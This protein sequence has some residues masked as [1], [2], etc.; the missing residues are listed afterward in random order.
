V[1]LTP[2]SGALSGGS[3]VLFGPNGG[4][5]VGGEFAYRSNIT[6]GRRRG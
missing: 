2:V 6:T 3:V 1:T 5:N 4:G